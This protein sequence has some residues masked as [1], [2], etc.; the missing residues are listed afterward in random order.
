[1]QII[2]T[3]KKSLF[4]SA[5]TSPDRSWTLPATS[6]GLCFPRSRY[7]PP[8][9][10]PIEGLVNISKS[11]I[12]QDLVSS[13]ELMGYGVLMSA[14]SPFNMVH[15]STLG[16][17]SFLVISPAFAQ[18][19]SLHHTYGRPTCTVHSAKDIATDD[20]P[21]ITEA[22]EQC[23]YGGNIL[24]PANETFHINSRLN[25]VVNDVNIDWKGEWLVSS[26]SLSQRRDRTR[27]I[28]DAYDT[29]VLGRSRV[30]AEQL[31]SHRIP[32]PRSWICLDWRPHTNRWPWYWRYQW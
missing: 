20:V 17:L 32:K 30:L 5:V 22:F 19:V 12:H 9:G 27:S 14:T 11:S 3:R 29:Q 4:P 8:G 23:G 28:A 2:I 18:H 31:L 10:N 21:A 26:P 13:R 1:M 24:F 16:L 7:D 25:P 15:F 6:C